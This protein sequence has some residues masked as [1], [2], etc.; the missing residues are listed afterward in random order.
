MSRSTEAAVAQSA[1]RLGFWSALLTSALAVVTLGI[2]FSTPPLSG[3]FCMAGCLEYPYTGAIARFPRDYYWMYPAMALMIPFFALSVCA[4]HYAPARNKVWAHLG[5]GFAAIS[6]AV[7]FLDYFVQ[8]SVI[9]PSLLNGELDGIAL[10]TQF[11][12]HGVF[13]AL[14]EAG[15]LLMSLALACLAPAFAGRSKVES[16]LRWVLIAGLVLSLAGLAVT[17]V[18]Y[19]LQRE[20]RYEVMVI[21]IDFLVLIAGGVL[22]A[23][24]FRRAAGAPG[25]AE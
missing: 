12:P 13:I 15:Y 6:A 3:P 17:A 2:A 20:Y 21:S 11:N 23:V 4:Y 8:V 24:A 18:V 19:G 14:E 5:V 25:A 22:A 7:L 1:S 9:Q 10:L 16:A